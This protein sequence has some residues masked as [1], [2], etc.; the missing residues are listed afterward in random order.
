M[1]SPLSH[2][3]FSNLPQ[4]AAVS[5]PPRRC[6]FTELGCNGH[7]RYTGRGLHLQTRCHPLQEHG[8]SSSS[9]RCAVLRSKESPP[10][11]SLQ[12]PHPIARVP[13]EQGSGLHRN[14]LPPLAM[15]RFGVLVH[16]RLGVLGAGTLREQ[17]RVRTWGK[18]APAPAPAVRDTRQTA[19]VEGQEGARMPWTH[20]RPAHTQ[21]GQKPARKRRN[22]YRREY[23][24]QKTEKFHLLSS[25]DAP[26]HRQGERQ[27][28]G[29]KKSM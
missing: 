8:R 13:A 24:Q 12:P 9:W 7:C 23:L 19:R 26:K 25:P 11:A 3:T 5:Q 4:L 15:H 20:V 18:A 6:I 29:E 2:S 27:T 10:P 21:R 17:G 14:L 28:D 16:H 1:V 22:K